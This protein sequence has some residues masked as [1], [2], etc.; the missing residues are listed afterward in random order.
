MPETAAAR[1]RKVPLKPDPLLGPLF[2][3]AGVVS[4]EHNGLI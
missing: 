1:K 3:A 4:L 2:I